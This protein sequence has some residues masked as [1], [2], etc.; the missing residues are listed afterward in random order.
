MLSFLGSVLFALSCVLAVGQGVLRLVAPDSSPR[1]AATL[2]ILVLLF[3]S[4]NL[5]AVGL[6][7]EYLAR[8]FEEVKRRPLYVRSGIVRDGEVRLVSPSADARA[9]SERR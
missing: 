5:F 2:V 8:V 6:V 1:G 9:V 7:G 3:G 4:L